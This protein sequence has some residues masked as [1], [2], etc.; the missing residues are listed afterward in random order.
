MPNVQIY[1]T[2]EL[3]ARGVAE[4]FTMLARSATRACPFSVALSGGNTP[5]RVYQLLAT[6]E[7]KNRIE[8]PL[9]HL[10][11]GDERMVPPSH[12]ASNYG[13][14]K[15]ALVSHVP[16]PEANVHRISGVG[17]TEANAGSY[18]LELKNFSRDLEWP[19]FD[20]VLLGMGDDGHTAS[21]F[22]GTRALAEKKAWVVANWVEKF[23][24]VRIT[25][26]VPAI[27]AAANVM[28]IVSGE[29]KAGRL[30]EVLDGPY[31]PERL[32]AQ[33]IK[34]FSGSLTWMTDKAAAS[35]LLR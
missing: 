32:P 19:R 11:F 16:I 9:I 34:P 10:F 5:R 28:F 31:D 33:L 1:D 26:T 14:V 18:Q 8:W 23:Q 35:Q 7:F 30:A 22:P 12:P 25:L 17:D 20:L 29:N 2:P 4:H 13:M 6:D 3:L 24:E 21:L 27:N 15:S